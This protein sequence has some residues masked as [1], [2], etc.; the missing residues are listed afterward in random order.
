[1]PLKI[2][3]ASSSPRRKELFEKLGI[4]FSI[5]P[6]LADEIPRESEPPQEFAVRASTE[7]ALAV[8]RSLNSGCVVIGADT[9]VVIDGE[10]LGKPGDEEE[11]R[12]ILKKISG[13]EHRVITGFSIVKPRA[14]V[15]HS[16]FVESRVK[17]KILAPWE[18]EGYINTKE[19]M[20]KAGAYG[21][22]GIG[23]FMVQEIHGSYTNIVGLPLA[24]LVGA[25]TKL[26]ILKL[27]SEDEYSSKPKKGPREN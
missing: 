7:K 24:Q 10:I 19:P 21:V 23:A 4:R 25:L 1:M 14:E 16:E 26:G 17:I 22:Q 20:D 2:I 5:I 9:I 11:A 15:L 18:I 12:F 8:A 3:L 13:R 27:F 6:S